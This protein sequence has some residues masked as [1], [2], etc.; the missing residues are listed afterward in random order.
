MEVLSGAWSIEGMN[1]LSIQPLGETGPGAED[2]LIQL[3][4]SPSLRFLDL[5][6]YNYHSSNATKDSP[7]TTCGGMLRVPF[8]DKCT[9][10][11][12]ILQGVHNLSHEFWHITDPQITDKGRAQCAKL[13]EDFTNHSTIE[14]VVASPLRRTICTALEAFSPVFEADHSPK[15]ILNPDLQETSDFPCDIGNDVPI[16]RKEFEQS[17]VSIDY[18]LIPDDWNTKASAWSSWCAITY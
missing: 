16:L 18:D 2:K 8:H 12:S 5:A 1:P 15:L 3:M 14:L 7:C 11:P 10:S 4:T 13:R 6:S 17:G 9:I